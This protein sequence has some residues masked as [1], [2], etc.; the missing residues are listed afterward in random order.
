MKTIVKLSIFLIAFCFNTVVAQGV[1]VSKP[2]KNIPIIVAEAFQTQFPKQDPIWYSQ[3]Q[4]RYDSK[5]VY[6]A[7]FTYDNRSSAAIF[8]RDGGLI[9]VAT[10]IEPSEIPKKA[11][12]YMN[13][14]YASQEISEALLVTRDKTNATVELGIYIGKRFNV[15]V[16]DK[17]GNFIKISS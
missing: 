4:G 9:A 14:N 11:V 5:L 17:E 15:V 7:R 3:Y 13:S 8:N 10:K 16:F 6:E 12:D 2:E 1:V